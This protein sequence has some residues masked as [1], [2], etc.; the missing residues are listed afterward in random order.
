MRYCIALIAVAA[1]AT[2]VNAQEKPTFYRDILPVLQ[3]NCQECHRPAGTNYGGMVAPMS[4]MTYEETRPWV[5]SMVKQVVS[6][7]M[8]PWDAALEHVGTF[9]NERVLTQDEID[10]IQRWAD[11]GA[12]RGNPADAPA[13]REFRNSDGWMIGEPDLVVPMPEPFHVSDDVDDLYAAFYVDLTEEQLPRDR[14]ITAFQCK[15]GSTIIH[16]F[17]CHLLAPVDGK[18]PPT[19]GFPD[20]EKG[21]IAPQGA[22]QYI[23]G[24]SSGTDANVYPPGF[25]RELAKGSRVTF[26]IH[27]HKEPGPG[28]GVTDLSHIG[29]K[30]SDEPPERVLGGAGTQFF[31]NIEI[32]P[33]AKDYQ[34]GPLQY[35]YFQDTD[36]I[37]LMPHMHMRGARAK[38]EAFYPDGTSEV[39]LHV[40]NY[41]FAWQTVYYFNEFKRLPAKTRLE[42]TAWYDNSEEMAEERGFD[43]TQTVTYGQKSTDEMMMGFVTSTPAVDEPAG[44]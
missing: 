1:S 3:E 39:L 7:E 33:G 23:G 34:L 35:T 17:N 32:P 21:E 8:P 25:G 2:A 9:R 18:L 19:Q 38:F 42:F 44:P 36:I 6:R 27:Y 5:K 28:T 41:D 13:P 30:L 29:F 43:H 4:L 26:D 16:H 24:V 37:G 14:W 15:P 31:F 11:S 12:P 10:L 22:G 40:P 20:T